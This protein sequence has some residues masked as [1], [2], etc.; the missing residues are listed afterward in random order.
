MI[1]KCEEC[2]QEIVA[3][4]IINCNES[5][6]LPFDISISPS[7][8]MIFYC[9]PINHHKHCLSA[10]TFRIQNKLSF[11]RL[12]CNEGNHYNAFPRTNQITMQVQLYARPCIVKF[13]GMTTTHIKYIPIMSMQGGRPTRCAPTLGS[14]VH[15][16][17]FF[18]YVSQCVKKR[19][20]PIFFPTYLLYSANLC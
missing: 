18:A 10:P 3:W 1:I 19:M 13:D 8:V 17:N 4:S 15:L 7:S 11:T 14:F 6:N 20:K 9:F 2:P 16:C 5:F 12:S